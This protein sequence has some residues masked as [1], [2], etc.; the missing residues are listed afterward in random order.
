MVIINLLV[1]PAILIL[2]LVPM[3]KAI[4][5]VVVSLFVVVNSTV[6]SLQPSARFATSFICLIAFMALLVSFLAQ[7]QTMALAGGQ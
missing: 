1:L 2:F 5:A 3:P 6:I 4:S 7:M